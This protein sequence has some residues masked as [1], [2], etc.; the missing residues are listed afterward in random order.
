MK[1]VEEGVGTAEALLGLARDH[2]IDLPITQQVHS[3]LHLGNSP[4]DAIR[5]IMERPLKH[6]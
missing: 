2:H 3:I 4:R 5:A 6:E 1:M